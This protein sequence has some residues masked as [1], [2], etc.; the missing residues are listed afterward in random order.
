[1]KIKTKPKVEITL[2]VE[3]TFELLLHK[4]ILSH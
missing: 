4:R 2:T 3:S 1:M